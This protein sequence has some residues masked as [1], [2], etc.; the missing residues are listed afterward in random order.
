QNLMGEFVGD[1]AGSVT[2]IAL[3]AFCPEKYHNFSRNARSWVDPF[4]DK[5]ARLTIAKDC[6]DVEYE[7]KIHDWKDFQER[8]LVRAGVV[9]T[10]G[11]A[12]NLI[13]Q[14]LFLNNK[15]PTSVIFAGK[16]VSTTLM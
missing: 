14:K 16:A 2:L 15:S 10:V 4:Y 6:P 13:S 1:G 3:E 8:N 12:A 9:G 5:L 7:K 11:I